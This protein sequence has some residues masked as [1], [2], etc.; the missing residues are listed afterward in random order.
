MSSINFTNLKNSKAKR[1]PDLKIKWKSSWLYFGILLPPK[2]EVMKIINQIDFCLMCSR[3]Q[4]FVRI[5]ICLGNLFQWGLNK[6]L[7]SCI[8]FKRKIEHGILPKIQIYYQ[9]ATCLLTLYVVF[10]TKK[11][12]NAKGVLANPKYTCL[13]CFNKINCVI[14]INW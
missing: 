2:Q 5:E 1:V 13:V 8:D 6:S 12:I 11:I 3:L 7:P 4:D 10:S 9:M 14:T